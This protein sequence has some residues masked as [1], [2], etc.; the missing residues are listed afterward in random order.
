VSRLSQR[1]S[2]WYALCPAH[3]LRV[4]RSSN[5]HSAVPDPSFIPKKYHDFMVPSVRK[6]YMDIPSTGPLTAEIEQLKK[7]VATLGRDRDAL[8]EKCEAYMAASRQYADKEK[9]ARLEA[10]AARE[11][12][13]QLQIKYNALMKEHEMN[14]DQYVF[15][16]HG[17]A[18]MSICARSLSQTPSDGRKRK[19]RASSLIELVAEPQI[20]LKRPR[21]VSQ[22]VPLAMRALP[23]SSIA[24]TS[25]R[26]ESPDPLRYP[27]MSPI[28][29]SRLSKECECCEGPHE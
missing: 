1:I 6:L 26:E 20:N 27:D 25:R 4:L 5:Y 11:A 3:C 14:L 9:T 7:R 19:N 18:V 16:A 21:Y 10:R 23:R 22:Y 12:T 13:S 24:S 17:F 2:Y 15:L 28:F 8:M 29:Q